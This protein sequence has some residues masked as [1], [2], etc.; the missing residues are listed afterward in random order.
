MDLD[1]IVSKLI[2]SGTPPEMAR[3]APAW[4]EAAR[5]RNAPQEAWTRIYRDLLTPSHDFALHLALYQQCYR[6]NDPAGLESAH[7][8]AWLPTPDVVDRANIT[9]AIRQLGLNN[10]AALYQW[11]IEHREEYWK[12]AIERLGIRFRH[13]YTRIVDA[14][15]STRPRW[16]VGAKMNIID[17]CF[18]A[19]PGA[20]AIIEGSG[21]DVSTAGMRIW[22]YDDLR[23]LTA[24]VANGL[25]ATGTVPGDAI[26]IVMPMTPRAVAIYLGIIASG[27]VVVSVA[28]SF[29]ADEI[30]IRFRLAGVKRVFTQDIVHWGAKLLPLYEKVSAA[31]A[32]AT[33]VVAECRSKP[34]TLSDLRSGD[35]DFE[36]FLSRNEELLSVTR[37]PQDPINILFSSGTTGE[38][39]AI[40]WDQTTPIKCAVDGHFHQD[41]HSGDVACWPTNMGWMMGPWLIFATLLN[42][43]TMALHPQAPTDARFGKFVQDAGVT[44][45]GLVP[46]LVRTWRQ[47]DCMSGVNWTRIRVFSSTGEC[48]NP[49]DMLFLMHLAGYRPIIEYCGGTEIGGAYVTG[50]VVQPCIPSTFSTPALGTGFVLLDEKGQL[51]TRSA[52][53][54]VF[55]DGISIGLSMR[56]LNRDHDAIYYADTPIGRAGMPLRRHGDELEALDGGYY[57][58]VGRCDDTM[59]LGGIKVGC[60]E[61]ERVLSQVPGVKETAA[62]AVAPPGGGPSRLVIFLVPL[63]GNACPADTFKPLLQQA[64]RTQLNPLFHVEEVRVVPSL[65]R[66]ASNKIMRRELRALYRH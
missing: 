49:Q 37:D 1:A 61:L 48:S 57:R 21:G 7:G 26:G 16:L 38:P 18:G 63:P 5:A 30:A 32:P 47:S 41:I 2:N 40:P 58:M 65:P 60:A 46:S 25:A 24:R 55:I 34:S 39:K 42:R 14:A 33:V 66:T 31:G 3:S 4:I 64:I 13:S 44:M 51:A 52:K 12:H 19:D 43:A 53:G 62:V 36:F 50:T 15:Q 10:Y 59:N 9:A 23:R 56:L 11:S 6:S 27:A 20:P 8:P 22:T 28:D 17:S 54:E 45:L 35:M 29:A